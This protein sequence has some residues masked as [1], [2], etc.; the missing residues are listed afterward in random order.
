MNCEDARTSLPLVLYGELSFDEE[1]AIESHLESCTEC[2]EEMARLREMERALDTRELDVSPFLLRQCRQQLQCSLDEE[3]A[4]SG[5]GARILTALSHVFA[6]S[7]WAPRIAKPAGAAA[8]VALGFFGSRIVPTATVAGFDR[9]GL[10]DPAARV[11]YVEPAPGGKVQLVIDE[12]TQRVIS[13]PPDDAQIRRLLLAAAK[14]PSDPGLRGECVEILKND[15][16]SH[17]V[18]GVLMAALEHDSNAGVRLKALEGLKP[19]AA[20]PEV[21]KALAQALLSDDNPGIRTQAIDLLIQNAKEQPLIGILQEL[22]R[23]ENNSYVRLQ[24]QKA[25]H[26]M[27]A[28]AETY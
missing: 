24:C 22:L 4:R 18:R 23:K 10:L 15:S 17:D 19:Y 14:D 2:R 13:G 27:R 20:Q 16:D 12:T 28:S 21:R 3:R 9:A 5:L 8:L 1:E 11:R 26:E 7:S 25:L 6:G